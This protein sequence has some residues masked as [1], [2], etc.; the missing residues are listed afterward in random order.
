MNF[1]KLMISAAWA[2]GVL[3]DDEINALKDLRFC[4]R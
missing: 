2:D 1:G 3:A 4:P